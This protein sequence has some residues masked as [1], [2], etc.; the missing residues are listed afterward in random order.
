VAPGTKAKTLIIFLDVYINISNQLFEALIDKAG[1]DDVRGKL[2]N[3]QEAVKIN[4][5]TAGCPSISLFNS[6]RPKK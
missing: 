6:K 2:E 3:H 5:I 4:I 1:Y